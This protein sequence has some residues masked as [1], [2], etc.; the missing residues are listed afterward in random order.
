MRQTTTHGDAQQDGKR[1]EERHRESQGQART[2]DAKTSRRRRRQ[3]GPWRTNRIST[4]GDGVG[5]AS[6]KG[7]PKRKCRQRDEG[8]LVRGSVEGNP[9]EVAGKRE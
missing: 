6:A 7:R 3:P 1:A 2:M 5:R 4:G 8:H 9:G